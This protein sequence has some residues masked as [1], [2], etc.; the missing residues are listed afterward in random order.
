ML[1]H[2]ST[3]AQSFKE[4]SRSL[5]KLTQIVMECLASPA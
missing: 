5:E 4:H 3:I 2:V 1:T